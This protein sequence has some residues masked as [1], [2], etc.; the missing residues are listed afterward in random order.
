MQHVII[1]ALF[2]QHNYFAP[3]KRPKRILD[4][5]CG[6]GKWCLEMGTSAAQQH[7]VHV[8]DNLQPKS[9]HGLGYVVCTLRR[10]ISN[11]ASGRRHRPLS[12]PTR[13]VLFPLPPLPLPTLTN[14]R[15]STPANVDFFIDDIRRKEWWHCTQPYDYI[16]TRMSLGIFPDFREII[17]KAFNNLEPGGFCESH[18]IYPK[19]YCD[20]GTMPPNFELL[21]WTRLQDKAAMTLGTPLRI[22]NKL[23]TWYEQAG[24]VDVKED[25]WAIPMNSWARDSKH[26]LLGKFMLWN[27][28]QGLHAWTVE[29]FVKALQW[30]EA[31][32]EVYLAHLRNAIADRSVH[33]YYKVYVEAPPF[34]LSSPFPLDFAR[35]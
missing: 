24:F 26:K 35:M 1:R 18:E 15:H 7:R 25:I 32:V 12:H 30:T 27:L 31:E 11:L 10:N 28:C 34:L 33:G 8:T 16:H 29:Y 21:E 13:R 19:I 2:E 23:K 9:S 5:G 3:L 20:D 4:I 22:A 17:Q 14:T 6:T